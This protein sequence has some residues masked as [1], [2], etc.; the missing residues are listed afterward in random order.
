MGVVYIGVVILL[1]ECVQINQYI[2]K[3][4]LQKSEIMKGSAIQVVEV[5]V[6]EEWEVC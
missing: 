4:K 6:C 3:Q 5:E 2:K 1:S